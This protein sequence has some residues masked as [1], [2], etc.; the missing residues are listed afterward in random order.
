MVFIGSK[1]N[2]IAI[3]G[4][5]VTAGLI[6]LIIG[7]ANAIE[8]SNSADAYEDSYKTYLAENT[9][10][11]G[12]IWCVE[13]ILAES[14]SYTYT[15]I[16]I[17]DKSTFIN[18]QD[19]KFVVYCCKNSKREHVQE[20]IDYWNNELSYD[21]GNIHFNGTISKASEDIQDGAYAYFYE[22]YGFDKDQSDEYFLPYIITDVNS[23]AYAY[24]PKII[25]GAV[26][27]IIGILLY[28]VLSIKDKHD[29]NKVFTDEDIPKD[30]D[31][32]NKD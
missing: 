32:T 5:I 26:F 25:V 2:R 9:A 14:E 4:A 29:V 31:V 8:Y 12:D 18:Q 28:A 24:M 10:I 3:C 23:F 11:Q 21:P 7:I 30:S 16:P 13:G 15:L 6:F 19:M 1:I 22:T 17:T 27:S 20:L